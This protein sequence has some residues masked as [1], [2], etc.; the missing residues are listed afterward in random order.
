MQTLH[1]YFINILD[2]ICWKRTM[3]CS[4]LVIAKLKILSKSLLKGLKSNLLMALAL[5]L[6]LFY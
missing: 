5:L 6:C 2:L 3:G 4:W 1:S